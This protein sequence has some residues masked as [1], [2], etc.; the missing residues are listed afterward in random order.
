M[1]ELI[2][3]LKNLGFSK[4]IDTK[5]YSR[6]IRMGKDRFAY[7]MFVD[8]EKKEI[9]FIQFGVSGDYERDITHIEGNHNG[10]NT[11][12]KNFWLEHLK[13]LGLVDYKW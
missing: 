4:V 3:K 2:T 5:L 6:N 1:K 11:G 7:E 10:L 8:P 13:P 9:Y 12:V